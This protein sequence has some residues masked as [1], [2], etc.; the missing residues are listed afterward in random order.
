[1]DK[2]VSFIIDELSDMVG[3]AAVTDSPLIADVDE[4]INRIAR[5]HGI[6]LTLATQELFQL[7]PQI[8]QTVLSMGTVIF[9]QT[10][11]DEAAE[12]L[13]RRYYRYDPYMVKKSRILYET[14]T[15]GTGRFRKSET[16]PA[17][18]QT[19]EFTKAEQNYIKSRDFLDLEPFHFLIGESERE[20]RL[21]TSLKPIT[22]ENL[23][24]GE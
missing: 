24:V 18:E 11:D 17:G 10:S 14:F 21:P 4:L 7:P 5:S 13:A 9:G 19:T 22:T 12:A 8:R 3:S 23:D 15:E 2:P 16:V 6:W 20:G 1:M